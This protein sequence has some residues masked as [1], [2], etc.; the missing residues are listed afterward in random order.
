M[1]RNKLFIC[2]HD[3]YYCN[4]SKL[5]RRKLEMRITKKP[6]KLEISGINVKN[7]YWEDVALVYCTLNNKYERRKIKNA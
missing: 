4:C 3:Y 7:S 2:R 1:A 6:V 5:E